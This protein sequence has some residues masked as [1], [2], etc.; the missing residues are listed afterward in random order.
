MI[1]VTTVMVG[2]MVVVVGYIVKRIVYDEGGLGE[3]KGVRKIPFVVFVCQLL[4]SNKH[5]LDRINP[6][7]FPLSP[8]RYRVWG[9]EGRWT[10]VFSSV[11]AAKKICT[12]T[13]TFPKY[14]DPTAQT[15]SS[16]YMFGTNIVNLNGE[17]WS[18]LHHIFKPAFHWEYLKLFCEGFA[19]SANMAL[20]WIQ[21]NNHLQ[22]SHNNNLKKLWSAE[23]EKKEGFIVDVVPLMQRLTLDVLGKTTF[24]FDFGTLAPAKDAPNYNYTTLYNDILS[25]IFSPLRIFFHFIDYLPTKA[26]K[27][28]FANMAT[29]SKLLTDVVEA[30]RKEKEKGITTDRVPDLL[31]HVVHANLTDLQLRHNMNIFFL[32]GHDTTSTSLSMALNQLALNPDLQE[33]A[34]EEAMQVLGDKEFPDYEDQKKLVL[35]NNIIKESLRMYPP[36]GLLPP[37][38]TASDTVID[39]LHVPKGTLVTLGVYQIHHDP[40]YWQSPNL[41]NPYRFSHHKIAPFSW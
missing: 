1:G 38:I 37:R 6:I 13:E 39:G 19:R 29:F 35:I 14:N 26:N 25:H 10:V 7:A 24:S 12:E 16:Q 9:P 8:K 18:E 2:V 36:V 32:A 40:D 41:F 17:Q 20:D 15:K 34:R 30:R 5:V 11:E 21:E 27:Q 33:L 28:L 4:F 22:I 3:V 31:D 23:E